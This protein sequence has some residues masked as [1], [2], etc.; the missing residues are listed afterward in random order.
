MM[1]TKMNFT[2]FNRLVDQ[3]RKNFPGYTLPDDAHALGH[4]YSQSGD[5]VRISQQLKN[6]LLQNSPQYQEF[7]KNNF[8]LYENP[9]NQG[10]AFNEF[11][12]EFLGLTGPAPVGANTIF[13]GI[14][15]SSNPSNLLGPD[16]ATASIFGQQNKS[17]GGASGF[18][19]S[20]GPGDMQ[21]Y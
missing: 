17:P 18:Q 3:Y 9:N 14:T 12:K 15:R 16:R 21:N 13:G 19:V 10:R 7:K 4:T 6:A 8:K 5:D 11:Q 1:Q 2:V 20:A